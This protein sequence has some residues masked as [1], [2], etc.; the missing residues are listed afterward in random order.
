MTG[1]KRRLEILKRIKE[2]KQP[3]PGKML[4]D[5]YQV[6]RQVIVQ[7]IALL[8]AAGHDIEATNRGY[9]IYG[10]QKYERIFCVAHKDEQIEDE[11]NTIVDLGGRVKDVFVRHGVYGTIKADLSVKSRREVSVFLEEI[12]TGKSRPLK[13]LTAGLHY[14]TVEADAEE[15]LELIEKA[16]AQKGFLTGRQEKNSIVKMP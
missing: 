10:P 16:L 13:N 7:D 8:R 9:V 5:H 1:E 12:R 6:S 2:A 3:V 11:L 4:A 14:H 15:I